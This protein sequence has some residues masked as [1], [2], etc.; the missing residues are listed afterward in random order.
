MA[1]SKLKRIQ[2]RVTEAEHELIM[3]KVEASGLT[4]AALFRDHLGKVKVRNRVDE[5]NRYI[6]LRRI[7]NS[8]NQI[9]RWANTHKSGADAVRIVGLLGVVQA[10]IERLIYRMDEVTSA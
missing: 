3:E 10:T 1:E 9:A 6:M 4:M 7:S 2:F 8:L 5:R